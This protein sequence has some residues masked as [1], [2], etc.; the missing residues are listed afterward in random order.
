MMKRR[1]FNRSVFAAAIGAGA[2]TKLHAQAGQVVKLQIGF[3]PGGSGDIVA[4]GLAQRLGP[5]LGQTV[6]VE[7]RPGAGGRLAMSE[8]K[9]ATPDGSTLLLTNAGPF[10]TLP[11][12]Y[13]SVKVG[14]DPFKDFVQVARVA[15]MDMGIMINLRNP[16]ITDFPTLIQYLKN[17]PSEANYATPG[18]GTLPHFVGVMLAETLRLPLRHIA[19]RGTAP[20]MND[21]LGGQFPMMVDTLWVD[22]HKHRGLKIVATSGASRYRDLPD[23]PTL[24]EL[25]IDLVADSDW[26][27]CAPAAVPA[28]TVKRTSDAIR[29][30]LKSKELQD[31]LYG[32]GMEPAFLDSQQVTALHL[33]QYKSWEKPIKAS[34]YVPE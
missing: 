20:A 34:G 5:I 33:A 24:K 17:N 19:Y 7:N 6:I 29:E 8:F 26:C 4:R 21:F 28:E 12:L 10:T 13:S 16:A 25:G 15:K 32:I 14:F 1:D 3:A 9:R 11:W 18:P 30:A 22:R 2:I 31:L 27:V 23:V